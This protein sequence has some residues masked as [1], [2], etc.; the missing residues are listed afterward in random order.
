[1]TDCWSYSKG[2]TQSF[3][4]T[5]Q[6]CRLL[7]YLAYVKGWTPINDPIYFRH[8]HAFHY[9]L[10]HAYRYGEPVSK[11]EIRAITHYYFT[12]WREEQPTDP[13]PEIEEENRTIQRLAEIILPIYFGINSDDFK[14]EWI[15]TEQT[16]E[17]PCTSTGQKT[18]LRGRWDGVFRDE[19]TN[20][21]KLMDHKCLSIIAQSEL[22]QLLPWDTQLN[23][24][25]LAALQYY[26]MPKSVIFNI[27]RRP[28]K[29]KKD[30]SNEEWLDRI[31]T[32]VYKDPLSFF[33]RLEIPFNENQLLEWSSTQLS[34]QMYEIE[35]WEEK[36]YPIYPY[37][38]QAWFGKYGRSPYFQIIESGNTLGFYQRSNPF[39]ELEIEI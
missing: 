9:V 34:A 7:T 23:L 19:K 17:I 3:I 35:H 32:K 18:Y 22:E 5:F 37:N 2:I 28:R 13:S 31:K 29:T 36:D 16:F 24:Y 8:G 4:K 25:A 1:M 6:S 21:I 33:T 15:R 39:P 27:L 20:Q 26:E 11:D 14:H 30:E 38:E 10:E 12:K